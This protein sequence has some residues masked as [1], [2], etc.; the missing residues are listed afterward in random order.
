M[1]SAPF[2]SVKSVFVPRDCLHLIA[3]LRRKDELQKRTLEFIHLLAGESDIHVGDF[4][5]HGSVAL[6]MHTQKSDIDVV[7][8]GSR[9]FRRLESA[10]SRLVKDG[11]LSYVCGNRLDAARHFKGRCQGRIFM[12]NA[13]RK[14]EEITSKYGS[15]KYR[16]LTHVRFQCKVNDDSEAMFRPAIYQIGD[17]KPAD[18]DS[19]IPKDRIPKLVVSMIGCY[20]NIARQGDQMRVSGML[21]RVENLETGGVTH[22]VVVGT[23][24]NEEEYIWPL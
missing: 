13:I 24:V 15:H 4:G 7:V 22:Q 10:V 1:I 21:E 14:P 17:Y 8:Y 6:G 3:K 12:Y 11:T 18:V 19:E 9:N 2:V 23:G 5:V 20:R 16:P